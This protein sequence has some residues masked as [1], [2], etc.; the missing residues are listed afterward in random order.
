[1]AAARFVTE[2]APP[3]LVPVMRRGKKV[4]TSLDTIAE[5]DREQLVPASHGPSS[6]DH[7][8]RR[9]PPQARERAAGF[10]SELSIIRY[11]HGQQAAPAAGTVAIT[12]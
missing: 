4:P 6:S 11:A 8:H 7:Y 10:M 1:M 3:Q 12:S 9:A 2:V 5:D